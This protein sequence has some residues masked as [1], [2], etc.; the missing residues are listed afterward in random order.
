VATRADRSEARVANFRLPQDAI[1]VICALGPEPRE[2]MMNRIPAHRLAQR[3]RTSLLILGV[4]SVWLGL[5]RTTVAGV[6]PIC[7]DGNVDGGE[8]CDDGNTED[9]DCCSAT[10]QYEPATSP[11]GD[12]D[13]CNGEESCD[14][15]GVCVGGT[16]PDC[17]DGDLCTQDSCHPVLGCQN[18]ATPSAGCNTSW[19]KA[20]LLVKTDVVG[21]EKLLA[22]FVKGPALGQMDFGA[23][24]LPGGTGYAL[25]IYDDTGDFAGGLE[26]DRAGQQCAG[27]DCWRSVGASGLLYK[28]KDASSDGTKLIKLLG[29]DAEKS[30]ILVKAANNS[31][32]GQISLPTGITAALA[33]STNATVQLFRS[34]TADCFAATLGT[35]VK[36][37]ADFFK[38][39]N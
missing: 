10:C 7:G 19:G 4:L 20:S 16:G 13:L 6:L 39:K 38:A 18:S 35:V 5:P 15:A 14:G 37:E 22:K 3:R 36:N 8:A 34:D 9:G 28:D 23:P 21:K 2:D 30:K 11:C 25:C 32:K 27:K 1:M 26:V 17:D 24:L 31:S 33:G 29:G 12:G